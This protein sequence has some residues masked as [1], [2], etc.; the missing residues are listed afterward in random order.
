[1][2]KPT[3]YYDDRSPPVR[4][5]LLLIKI[6]N[7]D[8]ELKFIDLFKGE[9][10]KPEYVEINPVHCVPFLE[11]NGITLTDSHAILIYLCEQF[12][13]GADWWPEDKL[14]RIDVINK[15]FLECSFLFRRDSD[16]M[17]EIVRKGFD[18]I[19]LP[20]H[21]RK[22]LEVYSALEKNLSI[23]R[24]MSGKKMSVADLSFLTTLSTVDLMFAI[25][26]EK[27]PRLNEWFE[28]MKQSLGATYTEC[29]SIGLEKLKNII[30]KMGKFKFPERS[31]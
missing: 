5:C 16:M 24:F 4:S 29:N 9:Q 28:N 22:I 12:D 17:T 15:L 13:G 1:M 30:E 23:N 18:N 31:V 27:W 26:A 3:L 6:L 2:M 19:D 8:V 20:F 14:Q 25:T 10:L 21:E 7:I 11:H